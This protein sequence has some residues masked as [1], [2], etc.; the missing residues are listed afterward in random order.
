MSPR[1]TDP[2][3]PL[4]GPGSP[5]RPWLPHA[6][7]EWFNAQPTADWIV[8][9]WGSGW[10]TLYFAERC[11]HVHAV[12]HDDYWHRRITAAARERGLRNITFHKIDCDRSRGWPDVADPIGYARAIDVAALAIGRAFEFILVD[13]MVRSLCIE[14]AMPHIGRHIAVDNGALGETEAGRELL[15]ATGWPMQIAQH[16]QIP[17]TGDTWIWTRPLDVVAQDGEYAW[18]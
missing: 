15:A 14:R 17:S 9:E 2:G 16:D 18:R 10:S 12:E 1:L 5:G 7:T 3:S 8:F 11:A 6:F 13:G 4:S